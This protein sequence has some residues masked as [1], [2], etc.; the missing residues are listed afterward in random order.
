EEAIAIYEYPLPPDGILA[1][2]KRDDVSRRVA[3]IHG[4]VHAINEMLDAGRSYS[5]IVHQIVAVRS[6]LDSV[7]QVI[8]DDLVD[9]CLSR[10]EKGEGMKDSLAQLQRVVATIR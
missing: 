2:H 9:D 4:H 7:I 5:E 8:V 3:R 1:A 10:S 6:A